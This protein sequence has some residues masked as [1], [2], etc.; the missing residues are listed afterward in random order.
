MRPP[1]EFWILVWILWT[2]VLLTVGVTYDVNHPIPV[3]G[4][5]GQS[6]QSGQRSSDTNMDDTS[7]TAT[8]TD[9]NDRRIS[10]EDGLENVEGPIRRVVTPGKLRLLKQ[11][12]YGSGMSLLSGK[13][14]AESGLSNLILL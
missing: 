13:A 1:L 6:G 14:L 2:Q 9:S 10:P 4:S 12:R 11:Y 7:R 3:Y 5:S 8:V